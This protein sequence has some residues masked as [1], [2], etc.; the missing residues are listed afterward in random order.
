[1]AKYCCSLAIYLK[2]RINAELIQFYM[3][4]TV[5]FWNNRF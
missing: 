3:F 4:S 1:M 2:Y 5:I